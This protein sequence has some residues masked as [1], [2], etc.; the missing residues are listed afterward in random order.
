MAEQ[1]MLFLKGKSISRSLLL[2][3]LNLEALKIAIVI[4]DCLFYSSSSAS[5][6]EH[7]PLVTYWY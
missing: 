4:V 2:K 3:L 6:N 7:A 1:I 5:W